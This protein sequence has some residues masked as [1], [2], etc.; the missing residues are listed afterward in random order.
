MPLCPNSQLLL[1]D[2]YYTVIANAA[3]RP[4]GGALLTGMMIYQADLSSQYVWDG[5]GWVL[6]SE[7]PRVWTPQVDQGAFTNIAKTVSWA[8]YKRSDGWVS[9]N[10]R[11]A[12]TGTGGPGTA[13]SVTAPIAGVNVD[14]SHNPI[15]IGLFN[16][17]SVQQ[18][19]VSTNIMSGTKF[20]F[21][22]TD[23]AATGFYGQSPSTAIAS[24][25]GVK[26]SFAYEMATRYS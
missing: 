24:G 25:D 8:R 6:M 17:A 18:Y 3:A 2:R 23:A 5:T 19:G 1:P 14:T 22:L 26:F 12:F 7:P 15:G 4:T 10:V 13:V 21:T 11:L 20:Q 16:D 9:G